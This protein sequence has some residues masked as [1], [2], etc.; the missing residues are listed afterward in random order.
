M[1]IITISPVL[2]WCPSR[3]IILLQ[4]SGKHRHFPKPQQELLH[5][6]TEHSYI[7]WFRHTLRNAFQYIATHN[8]AF[9][10]CDDSTQEAAQT[11]SSSSFNCGV[12]VRCVQRRNGACAR[13]QPVISLAGHL[14]EQR[15]SSYDECLCPYIFP[16]D[17][18]P[19]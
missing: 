12:A 1:P 9:I 8:R 6:S 3:T 18:S 10:P 19:S 17:P 2:K 4:H 14:E 11:C 15:G 5:I 7:T 16:N 13:Q